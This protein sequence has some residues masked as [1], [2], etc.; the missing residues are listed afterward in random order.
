MS[1]QLSGFIEYEKVKM[2]QLYF[3]FLK[4]GIELIEEEQ[5]KFDLHKFIERK[6]DNPP[7]NDIG[8]KRTISWKAFGSEWN[9][10][11][12]NDFINNSVGEEFSSLIQIIQSEIALSDVDFHL[13]K[14]RINIQIELVVTPKGPEQ[15]PS[16]SLYQWKVFLPVL[17]S[18]DPA[19]KNMHYAAI[20]VCFQMILNELSLLPYDDF[21][22][23]FITLFKN[24]LGNRALTINA[25]QRAYR[26]L[27][28][29]EK[30]NASMR[31]KFTSEILN[32]EQYESV[33]LASKK[34]DSPLYDYDKS[35]ENIKGRYINSLKPIH[36]TIERLKQSDQ[37]IEEYSRLK[38]EGWLDWQIVLALY[39]NILDLKAK[40]ILQQNGK[41]YANDDE[42]LLDFKR[43]FHNIR[44]KDETETYVEIPIKE[45]VGKN[46]HLQLNHLTINV[47]SS[48]G[49]E[50]K[51]R[52]PNPDAVKALLIERFRFMDDD[53]SELSPFNEIKR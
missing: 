7:I 46:L 43:T 40:N 9:V 26:D 30:F 25:Y 13:I 3:D 20:T 33:T 53:V 8:P 18:K 12:E 34:N 36:L 21:H 51:S 29:E 39:N 49:L 22:D 35:I 48:L 44:F 24:G 16:N 50:N 47:L 27:V 28:S 38:D 10:E 2:G 1:N 15:L 41:T 31:N 6:L 42:W 52:F 37:F 14:G 32:I 23:A 11:F 4:D 19:D 17:N 5:R 45:I